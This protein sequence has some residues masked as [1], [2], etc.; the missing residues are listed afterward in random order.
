MANS[1]LSD[2]SQAK[3]DG[4]IMKVPRKR[5]TAAPRSDRK[6][7]PASGIFTPPGDVHGKIIGLDPSEST[8]GSPRKTG[9]PAGKHQRRP[10]KSAAT[11]AY[12]G[13]RTGSGRPTSRPTSRHLGRP[14]SSST[15]RK[16]GPG[17][18][19]RRRAARAALHSGT[20][21][22]PG[23][24]LQKVLAAAGFGSRR[25][26][27]ELITTG[28]VEID[29]QVV[30]QLGTRVETDKQQIRVDGEV[31]NLGRRVYYAVNKPRGVVSTNSDPSGRP[32]VVDLVPPQ[33]NRCFTIGRLDLSSEGL[34][35]VTNDGD[36]AN[37]LTHPRYGVPKTYLVQVAGKPELEILE[38]LKKGVHLAEGFV[39]CEDL[40]VKSQHKESTWLEVVLKEGMNRE[41][42][43]LM[44]RVGH[45]VMRL[46][47]V[48]VGPIKLGK[49]MPGAVRPLAHHE[50]EELRALLASDEDKK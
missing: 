15:P 28:R 24:R 50:I 45:K 46:V 14:G 29:R 2:A 10:F 5:K 34:I 27:E 18:F 49:L 48:A 9:V 36:L 16:R 41:I 20:Q 43:R 12:K 21:P 37:R 11:T 44:A 39:K 42:R 7:R 38:K 40:R 33:A 19:K 8:E 30:M 25:K 31:L 13:T 1:T 3:Y 32:R 22:L 4:T 23:D 35:I 47:R 26:C 6:P 17:G